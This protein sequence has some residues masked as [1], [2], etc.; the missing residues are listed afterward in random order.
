MSEPIKD[1]L[2]VVCVASYF[3]GVEF[4]REAKRQGCRVVLVTKEKFRHEEW[5]FE[6]L[7]EFL[8][9]P[10]DASP[11]LFVYTVA[12]LARARKL[13]AI[14]ALEEFDVLTAALMREHLRLPGMG[15]TTARHFRDKLAMRVEAQDAGVRVPE[16]VHVLNYRDLEDYMKRISPP[17][18]MKPRTDVSAIGIMKMHESEQVW[19]TIDALDA[20]DRLSERSNN[21]VLERYVPGDVYHVDSLVE[22]GEVVFAGA[23]RYG[24]PPM[25][26]A[27]NGG[28]F[29]TRTLEYGSPERDELLEINRKLLKGLKLRRGATHAEFIKGAADGKFYFLEVASRVGGAYIAETLEAASGINIWAEWAKIELGRGERPYVLPP[30]RAEYGGVALCL[31][32]QEWPD[33]SHFTDPEIFHRI[34]KRY[35]VG[36]VVRSKSHERVQE[37]LSDYVRRFESEFCAVVPPLERP[38]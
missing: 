23:N 29:V 14:V 4:I 18:V 7:D 30:Q 17:W 6:S 11:E 9:L 5:P 36:L 19:R 22:N 12:Q 32:K 28:V 34:R 8:P 33:T 31:A 13:H 1:Q 20:R 16:F 2:T 38:E 24:R 26:V 27:H 3:K 25:D 15:S 37:L 21:Y 35:H 10:N